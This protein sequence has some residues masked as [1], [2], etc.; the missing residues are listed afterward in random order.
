MSQGQRISLPGAHLPSV[1]TSPRLRFLT[2]EDR[3]QLCGSLGFRQ[4]YDTDTDGVYG[5]MG[6]CTTGGPPGENVVV[7]SLS[8]L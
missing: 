5:Q 1:K 4:M 2:L 6:E 7:L 8:H 3:W